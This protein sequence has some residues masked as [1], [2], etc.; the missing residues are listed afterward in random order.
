MRIEEYLDAVCG[1]IRWKAARK[2]V[3][4]EIKSHIEQRTDEYMTSGDT[5][6]AAEEKA[7]AN[8]GDAKKT[9][10]ELDRLHR[11]RCDWMLI[12]ALIA[13]LILGTIQSVT[14]IDPFP[15]PGGWITGLAAAIA[16]CALFALINYRSLLERMRHPAAIYLSCLAVSCLLCMFLLFFAGNP[17]IQ[18]SHYFAPILFYLFMY[19][20]IAS[21]TV[22][23]L[24]ISSKK[25]WLRFLVIQIFSVLALQI[26]S[27]MDSILL[28]LCIWTVFLMAKAR[29]KRS[30]LPAATGTVFILIV[31]YF[32]S[33]PVLF[34]AS[35]YD[36]WKPIYNLAG[37]NWFGHGS[38]PADS[39]FMNAYPLT[40]TIWQYGIAA[41]IALV[42]IFGV[43]LWRSWKMLRSI[44][45][46][47]GRLLSVYFFVFIA[48]EVVLSIVIGL[49]LIPSYINAALPMFSLR[50]PLSFC[51]G[52]MIGALIGLYRMK[53][54]YAPER[55]AE[56]IPG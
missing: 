50:Y 13:L 20:M 21:T 41:G 28:M 18:R 36:Y 12:G 43:V 16:G 25:E 6:E 51:Q 40:E 26:I 34:S 3:R 49:G 53:D 11:P 31:W 23:I 29:K 47:M 24:R 45:D 4:D 8:M 46:A 22:W 27:G 35:S 44:R 48:F 39:F 10:R 33:I 56:T 7:V 2:Q 38:L 32:T 5:Q 15:Y 37:I 14:A 30:I 54:K 52:S 17:E 55:P 1:E 19:G 42:C 9:G